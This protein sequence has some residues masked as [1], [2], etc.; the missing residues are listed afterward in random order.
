MSSRLVLQDAVLLDGTL[1]PKGNVVSIP[2]NV[3]HHDPELYSDPETFDPF[4]FSKLREHE[5]G[6]ISDAK[7]SFTTLSNDYVVFG[8][9]Y[10]Y[11]ADTIDLS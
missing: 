9:G 3:I 10:V 1:V 8:V 7:H 4:R 6:K 11:F 2:P 5:D